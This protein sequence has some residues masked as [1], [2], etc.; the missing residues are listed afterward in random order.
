[1]EKEIIASLC[2]LWKLSW[3]K[4]PFLGQNLKLECI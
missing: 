1:M 4:I 3:N 2:Q